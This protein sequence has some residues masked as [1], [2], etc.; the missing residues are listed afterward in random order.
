MTSNHSLFNSLILSHV[1]FVQVD[2]GD[3]YANLKGFCLKFTYTCDV[4]HKFN[5]S[6]LALRTIPDNDT[7]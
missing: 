1:K 7:I 6:S 5:N 3:S 4:D 2:N